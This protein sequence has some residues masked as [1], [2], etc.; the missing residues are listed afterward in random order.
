MSATF[1]NTL[2]ILNEICTKENLEN[3]PV[4]FTYY[5]KT[6][7]IQMARM[8]VDCNLKF[9][10]YV[11]KKNRLGLIMICFPLRNQLK[12]FSCYRRIFLRATVSRRNFRTALTKHHQHS[13]DTLKNGSQKLVTGVV[14]C[15]IMTPMFRHYCLLQGV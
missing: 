10:Q 3:G 15:H 5:V 11:L 13:H 7:T 2:K 8:E 14:D 1:R 12:T 6:P 9:C 4:S